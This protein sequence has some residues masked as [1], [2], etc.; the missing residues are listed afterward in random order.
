MK[1]LPIGTK[2]V[3][4]T[5]SV[6][7]GLQDCTQWEHA[8][9]NNGYLYIVGY[10]IVNEEEVYV[11]NKNK[12][13]KAGN[14][15]N[16]YKISDVVEYKEKIWDDINPVLK[17]K[18][19]YTAEL[20]WD[21]EDSFKNKLNENGTLICL[22][23]LRKKSIITFGLDDIKEI[24]CWLDKIEK[25]CEENTVEELSKSEKLEKELNNEK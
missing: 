6:W 4:Y 15:G 23:D 5:K 7:G 16:Y 18:N 2:V 8:K 9:N 3:P 20:E 25:Y 19:G 13:E 14:N 11:L 12:K 1:K 22:H 10:D 21:T 17:L 24:R